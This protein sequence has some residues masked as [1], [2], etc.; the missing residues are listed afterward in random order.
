MNSYRTSR[1]HLALAAVAA[2]TLAA[3]ASAPTRNAVL[4]DAKA[5]YDR[6]AS[7]PQV[8]RSAPVELR[9]AQQALQ[10]AQAALRDG[11]DSSAVE[12]YA[13]LARQRTEVA[14][15]A[16]KIAE[17]E[18]AVA[19][20]SL[21]RDSILIDARTREAERARAATEAQRGQADAAR[22]LADERLVAA[23]TSQAQAASARARAKTL[24]EQ[25]AELK[26]KPTERGMVLTL[27]D[28]LFDT[29]R[30][31]LNPGAA[32]TLDQLAA[33]M[34][35]HPERTIAIEGYTDAVGS[36]QSN[37]MLSER[38]AIAVKN[39]LVDRGIAPSRLSARGFGEA[40]PLAS[41]DHAAG[42]QQN[43]RVEIVFP[44][45]G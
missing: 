1:Y 11:D 5:A 17:A 31:Q 8:A 12:H 35:E 21:E 19:D 16:G 20:A 28:V 7:D 13:Y 9:K 38:R 18:Q 43:R 29:G 24:E 39:S 6:T 44:D 40:K 30:A 26:A 37:Q 42:R 3:C 36:E 10:Q 32:H 2:A 25:L 23:Q 14:L 33:F 27:G 4:D 15:Q 41:N 45:N 22:K 34:K